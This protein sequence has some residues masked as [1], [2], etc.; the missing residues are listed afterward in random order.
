MLLLMLALQEVSIQVQVAHRFWMGVTYH[1]S[2]K[3]ACIQGGACINTVTTAG[4]MTMVELV[5]GNATDDQ[6]A[7]GVNQVGRT[8][9]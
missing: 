4:P 8:R 3:S 6:T 9:L 5:R 7:L 1:R 2:N